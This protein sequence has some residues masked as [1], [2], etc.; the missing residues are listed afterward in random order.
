[1]NQERL[2]NYLNATALSILRPFLVGLM[3]LVSLVVANPAFSEGEIVRQNF[4]SSA[5]YG[6]VVWSWQ[7]VA[8]ARG[9]EKQLDR[10]SSSNSQ[11]TP[12][13][14]SFPVVYDNVKNAYNA[15][16]DVID[17]NKD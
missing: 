16:W 2:T 9:L 15:L 8:I 4:S 1:M 6:A 10:C 3:T 5:Y 12:E 14:R 11:P 13:F 17:E 7:L